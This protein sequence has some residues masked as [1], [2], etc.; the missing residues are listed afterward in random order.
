MIVTLKFHLKA[1]SP[2]HNQIKIEKHMAVV[3][4][5]VSDFNMCMCCYV[6]SGPESGLTE[7]VNV[8][9][10]A[11]PEKAVGPTAEW[12]V[13]KRITDVY[14][15]AEKIFKSHKEVCM[16]CVSALCHS[17]IRNQSSQ[18]QCQNKKKKHSFSHPLDKN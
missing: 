10:T 17:D 11:P 15:K 9:M 7:P 16:F 6:L 5:K 12:P 4:Y 14:F 8:Q 13:S 1:Q 3:C 2:D 18:A